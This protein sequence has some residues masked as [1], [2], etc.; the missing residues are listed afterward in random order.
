MRFTRMNG[1]PEAL[2]QA[3]AIAGIDADG[4]R[5]IPELSR[6]A[7]CGTSAIRG[8]EVIVQL[9]WRN[10]MC[11]SANVFVPFNHTALRASH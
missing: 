5:P 1:S 10:R 9:S 4:A 7:G 8:K 11:G 3:C 2:R 6:L